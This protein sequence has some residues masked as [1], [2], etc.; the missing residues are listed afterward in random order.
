MGKKDDFESALNKLEKLVAEI[1]G[2]DLT[3]EESLKSFEAGVSYYK[4]CKK[5]L[6]DVEKKITK[7]TEK[8]ND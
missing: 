5:K 3:L 8:L 4:D 7:L 2:G 6:L 1:E